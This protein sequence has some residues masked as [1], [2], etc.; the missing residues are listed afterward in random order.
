MNKNIPLV[1]IRFETVHELVPRLSC[2]IC[3]KIILGNHAGNEICF[4]YQ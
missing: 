1:I 4:C 2:E 3:S